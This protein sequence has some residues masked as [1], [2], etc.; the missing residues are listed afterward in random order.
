MLASSYLLRL[1]IHMTNMN[2]RIQQIRSEYISSSEA[3]K[4]EAKYQTGEIKRRNEQFYRVAHAL[5]TLVGLLVEEDVHP[6]GVVCSKDLNYYSTF[7]SFNGNRVY[8]DGKAEHFTPKVTFRG[9]SEPYWYLGAW[10]KEATGIGAGL[11]DVIK[12]GEHNYISSSGK[13]INPHL[14][15]VNLNTI[16]GPAFSDR[17]SIL[18]QAGGTR[19]TPGVVA[20]HIAWTAAQYDLIWPDEAPDLSDL[21]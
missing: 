12:D 8:A 7:I 18:E 11:Y 14:L 15:Y 6:E 4:R 5:G 17:I 3:A 10:D 21:L 20:Q 1:D 9:D 16:N 2:E 13:I 19:A